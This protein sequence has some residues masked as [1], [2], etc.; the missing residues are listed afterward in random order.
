MRT[1]YAPEIGYKTI[2]YA[3]YIIK[4]YIMQAYIYSIHTCVCCD[5]KP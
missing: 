1:Q 2:Y 3:M 5:G 4:L